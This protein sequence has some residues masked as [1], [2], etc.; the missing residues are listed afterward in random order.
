MVE[1]MVVVSGLDGGESVT[2]VVFLAACGL[3][4]ALLGGARWS[5]PFDAGSR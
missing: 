5:I 2:L 4:V 3:G 1:V